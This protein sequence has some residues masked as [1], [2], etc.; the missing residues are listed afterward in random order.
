MIFVKYVY[1]KDNKNLLKLI[2][3]IKYVYHVLN[4][5]LILLKSNVLF[6]SRKIGFKDIN[7]KKVY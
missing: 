5:Y 3:V 2:V 7:Q 1:K 6:V 4:N